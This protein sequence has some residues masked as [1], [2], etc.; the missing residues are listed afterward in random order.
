MRKG[1]DVFAAEDLVNLQFAK[2][3][4]LKVEA[5]N[6]EKQLEAHRLKAEH[7]KKVTR[8]I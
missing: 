1:I 3:N 4:N 2:I 7:D 5:D 6:K 8:T